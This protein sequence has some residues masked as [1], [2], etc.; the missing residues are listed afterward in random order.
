[1]AIPSAKSRERVARNFIKTYGRSRFRR[2]LEALASGGS[3]QAIADEFHVSRE[4]VRQWKNTFGQVITLYQL[5][6]E[7]ERVFRDVRGAG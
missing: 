5:H 7:V 1:M 3:G 6:P 2:L 4:R